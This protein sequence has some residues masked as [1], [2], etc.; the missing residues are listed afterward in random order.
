MKA[1]GEGIKMEVEG[2]ATKITTTDVER[3]VV[4]PCDHYTAGRPPYPNEGYVV[5]VV[6]Y[7]KS[8]ELLTLTLLSDKNILVDFT[9]DEGEAEEIVAA[10]NGTPLPTATE[11]AGRLAALLEQSGEE[12]FI[13]LDEDE[14]DR[15][16]R[17]N[18][19]MKKKTIQ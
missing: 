14:E 13:L 3:I 17:V 8:G 5:D 18:P 19:R 1:T 16:G 7:L 6:V 2:V 10:A 12:G 9:R 15:E 4:V 11:V